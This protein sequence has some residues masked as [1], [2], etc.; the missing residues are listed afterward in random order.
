VV[1]DEFSS[2]DLECPSIVRAMKIFSRIHQGK[3]IPISHPK[4]GLTWEKL[5]TVAKDPALARHLS[6]F[7]QDVVDSGWFW[8]QEI[9]SAEEDAEQCHLDVLNLVGTNTVPPETIL[10]KV[11]CFLERVARRAVVDMYRM[12]IRDDLALMWWK[13]TSKLSERAS[14]DKVRAFTSYRIVF[15]ECGI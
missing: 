6:A 10:A 2:L 8:F 14:A 4:F 3:D 12:G 11:D 1:D 15:F 9:W 5:Q 13:D 7:S